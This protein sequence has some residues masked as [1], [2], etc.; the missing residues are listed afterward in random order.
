MAS[1]GLFRLGGICGLLFVVLMVPAYVV[2]YPDQ[3]TSVFRPV[4]VVGYFGA[5]PQT[6]VLGN[7][8][9]PVFSTFFFLW[10]LGALYRLVRGAE[11]EEGGLSAAVLAGGTAF[12]VLSCVGYAAE[13]LYPA[14]L[15]RF[16]NF[17]P[18]PQQ[19]FLSLAL[20]AWLYHFC[21]VGASVMIAGTS[22][23]ALGRGILPRWAALLGLIVALLTL[24]HFVVPLLGALSGLLWVGLVSALMLLAASGGRSSSP[25]RL[26]RGA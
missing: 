16:E 4:D 3:P 26:A 11:G 6:F 25:R 12:I 2:G 18:D 1:V 7:G 17:A 9:V 15:L 24:L 8:I 13:I 23:A 21:Q 14:T 20:S 10:F 5:D 19:A 22:L